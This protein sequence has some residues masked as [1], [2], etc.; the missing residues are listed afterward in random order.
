MIKAE[1]EL[2]E[3]ARGVISKQLAAG[4]VVAG[5]FLVLQ[6]TWP[7]V[8]ALYGG[9]VSVSLSLLLLWG[10]TRASKVAATDPRKSMTIL[11]VGAVQRFVAVLALLALGLALF[12]LDPLAVLIGFG[13]AQVSYLV[14]SRG[15]SST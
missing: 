11:Y 7:A 9:V 10:V 4:V 3:Q 13:V 2:A 1:P 5:L 8:S 15:K 6:G 12:K 14:T